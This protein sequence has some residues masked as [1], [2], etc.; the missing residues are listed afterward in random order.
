MLQQKTTVIDLNWLL[1]C[2][3][4]LLS[5]SRSYTANEQ[6]TNSVFTN[7]RFHSKASIQNLCKSIQRQLQCQIVFVLRSIFNDGVCSIDIPGK[8]ARYRNL[9]A[10]LAQKTL[11]LR[12]SRENVSQQ[13]GQCQRE[14]R[15][16]D[17]SRFCTGVDQKSKATLCR[18]RLWHYI[19]KHRL[20]SGRNSYRS[21]F[22]TVSM[23]SASKSKKCGKT[24]YANGLKRL[25]THVC[26][27]YKWC[28]TR[29]DSFSRGAVGTF[30]HLRYGQRLHRFC[31]II[32]FFKEQLLLHYQSQKEYSLLS[33]AF[34][35]NRQ[36]H[37]FTKRPDNKTDRSKKFKALPDTTEANHFSRRRT[38]SNVR[39][40]NQQL[41]TGCVNNLPT[42]QTSL[43]DRVVLQMDQTTL[44]NKVVLRNF[45]QRGQD[46]GLDSDQ[47]LRACS[48]HQ[49]GTETGAF[50]TRNTPNYKY[51]T[52]RENPAKTSTYGQLLQ[53]QRTRKL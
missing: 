16:V 49:E 18:R 40:F 20:R 5:S 39:I 32:Q 41:S 28:C 1:S 11:S 10:G 37:G 36:E 29:S 12:L 2:G 8:L 27:Y 14:K 34:L 4:I 38:E 45:D 17:L 52:F 19:K 9:F 15:L 6:R 13:L 50:I 26:M 42:L 21:M 24:A 46:P 44:A 30:G 35:P 48:D 23:G 22:D 53:S 33:K 31:N 3:D 43:A 47:C 7:T 51:P 25:Y